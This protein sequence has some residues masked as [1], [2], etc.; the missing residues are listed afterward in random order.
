NIGDA[1]DDGDAG[2]YND[3]VDAN[4]VCAGT[5]YDCPNLMANI[6]DA[7]DDG[8]PNTTG[9]A[10][11]AN[12]VCT[13]TS[14]FDCPNLMAN[15]GDACDDGDPFTTGDVVTANCTCEG[16][17]LG[18]CTEI[19][20]LAITL[21]DFGSETHW[22]LY[23][24]TGT[25]LIEQGGP[26][27]D[28]MGGTTVHETLCL[29]QICYNLVMLDD[30]G[31]GIANGGYVLS[32]IDG[33]R[34]VDANGSFT[35][36]SS[37]QYPFC[38]PVSNQGL[39]SSFCDRMDLVY[40]SSTQIYAHF[41]PG[42]TGY[43]FWIFDPHGSYSRRVFRTTQ[44]LALLNLVTLPVPADIDLNVRVRAMIS[45][46]Y[47][48]FGSA[49]RMRLNTPGQRDLQVVEGKVN[50]NL[51]PNPNR[52]EQVY[53]VVDGLDAATATIDVHDMFGKL[54]FAEQVNITDG[55]INATM[56]LARDLPAGVY[57]VTIT[58]GDRTMTQRLIRQ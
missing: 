6:G 36:S 2:T 33:R 30:G 4:C 40:A 10:V 39:I 34:I 9:D 28:G 15:I 24:E 14:V 12:C 7:C 53:L 11:D 29:N 5:P 43:Q 26:Y 45:G 49:C 16:T 27:A 32:D 57:I 3:L 20:D 8:D 17:P 23:D 25:V 46:N 44:N 1:C 38:L 41:Q 31:D 54:V 35:S 52:G 37:V 58:G 56:D 42:A 47:T 13:G 21:D 18:N 22:E 55:S 50:V 48:P 19:L 51:Y